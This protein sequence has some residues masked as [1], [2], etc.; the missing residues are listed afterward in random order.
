MTGG[1]GLKSRL[2]LAMERFRLEDEAAGGDR[3]PVT[4][5]RKATIAEVRSLYEAKLAEMDILHQGKLRMP[6]DPETYAATDA[7]YRSTRARLAS[8]RDA[9]IE[10]ARKADPE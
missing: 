6:L 3:V 9:K 1:D 4:E 8:E 5:A 10:Q 7:E 2:E